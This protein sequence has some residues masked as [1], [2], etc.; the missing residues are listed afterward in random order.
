MFKYITNFLKEG[1]FQVKVSNTFYQENGIPQGSSLVVTLFLLDINDI[2][3]AI[4]APVKSNLFADDFN[5]LCRSNNLKAVQEFLQKSTN[6]LS[7][8]SKKTGLSFSNLKSQSIIFTKRKKMK[9]LKITL[10]NLVIPNRHEIKIL[11]ITF[12]SKLNWLPH[13]KNI[14]DSLSQK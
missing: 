11:G 13:L 10:D 8:W 12:D 9:P 3:K 2:V 5:I 6:S 4:Q 1:Q 7:D 14:R